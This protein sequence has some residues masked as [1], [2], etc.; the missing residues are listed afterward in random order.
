MFSGVQLRTLNGRRILK[1]TMRGQSLPA[2]GSLTEERMEVEAVLRSGI[3]DRAPGLE[4]LFIYITSKFLE[5][6]ADEIKEYNIAVEAFGR[7][8]DFDQSRDS[9]VRV[10]AH[11]LRERLAE[12]Y[13]S[14]GRS[15]PVQIEIP[16]GRYT[17]KFRFAASDAAARPL[18]PPEYAGSVAL[19]KIGSPVLESPEARLS[20][21]TTTAKSVDS[22]RILAGLMEGDYIDNIGRLWQRDQFW[23]GG[24]PFFFPNH[25]IFGT[26]DQR[27]YRRGR[28]GDF[29]YHIPLRSGVY[30]LRLHFAETTFG[31][32]SR[33]GFGGESSRIF[34]VLINGKPLINFLDVVAE[35]GA[36]TANREGPR[37]GLRNPFHWLQP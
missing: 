6:S 20:L 30:E 10:Q 27:L 33:A 31:E 28:E 12:Y 7:G 34:D 13:L 23:Q 15:H 26:R 21:P 37:T 2:L 25:L 35:A 1:S 3:F 29:S 4:Q 5:G 8:A 19:T 11:R 18:A 36:S 16:N 9:I 32:T 17:P 24:T 22:V 14:E